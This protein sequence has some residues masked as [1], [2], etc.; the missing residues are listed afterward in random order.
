MLPIGTIFGRFRR[1]VHD[2]GNQ[3]GKEAELITE[4]ADTELDKSVLDQLAEPLVHIVRNAMDH[5]VETASE[6][7]ASGKPKRA[8]IRLAAE[9]RGADVVVSVEDD[10]RGID[11]GAVRAKAM[12]R[13]LHVFIEK[14]LCSTP[15]ETIALLEMQAKTGLVVGMGHNDHSNSA[16]CNYLKSLMASGEMG[17]IA[18]FEQVTAHSGGLEIKPGDWRGDPDKNPGGMLFQCG[19]HALHEL[20]CLLHEHRRLLL[21]D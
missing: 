10:G 5:G 4:G 9:H 13:G 1:L 18:T 20:L 12:E 15:E 8:T 17:T 11:R 3:L 2:L 21:R 19:V 16:F 14:P 6:R 7:S